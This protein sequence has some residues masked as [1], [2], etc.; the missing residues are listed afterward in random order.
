[1]KIVIVIDSFNDGNGGCIA[2]KR[3]VK[4]LRCRGYKVAIVSAIHEDPSDP[5]FF[6][7]PGFVLP[8]A[9]D[10]QDNM[11]FLFGRS[12]RKVYE[13]AMKDAD[14]VQIQ[15]PFPMA[16]GAVNAAKR[17]GIPVVGAFHV[18]PQNIIAALGKNSKLLDRLFW[19]SFKYFLFKRVPIISCPSPFAVKLLRSEGVKAKMTPISNGIPVE[20]VPRDHERPEW[21]G[22]KLVL[23]NIGR[24]A[25]EKRQALLIEGVKRSKYAH[26]IQLILAG[27]GERTE[28]LKANGR[29]IPVQP[30]IEYI[31]FEDKLRYLNTA[32]LFVHAS[33]IEL[34]SLSCLEAI[35]CGLPCLISNSKYSAAS[36][37]ALDERFIFQSDDPDKL[38]S[39]LD[40]WYE[41]R[42]ELRSDRMKKAVLAKAESFRF[43][44][45]VDNYE[46]FIREAIAAYN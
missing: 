30:Y 44:R 29:E 3:L 15:F 23:L 14:I 17:L 5:D 32:D 35:G 20:Y 31:S 9:G 34:E 40:Y 16:K 41:N 27:R 19:F 45:A 25:N 43:A 21:F 26:K 46:I 10:A 1:M 39:A 12:D 8:G 33:I 22:D 18:Q 24:H 11:K 2:A 7:V 13:K 36:Q 38:A 4:E 6:Q 42:E 37:F 28:E